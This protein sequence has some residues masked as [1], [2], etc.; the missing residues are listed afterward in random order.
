MSKE[1]TIERQIEALE[2]MIKQKDCI[3]SIHIPQIKKELEEL[4]KKQAE[5]E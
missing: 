2:A 1:L 5:N 4:K 3:Q